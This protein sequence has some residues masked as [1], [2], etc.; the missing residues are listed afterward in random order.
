M[1][2]YHKTNQI[3]FDPISN[4]QMLENNELSTLYEQN[5]IK[6]QYPIIEKNGT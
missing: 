1:K 4:K 6:L 2:Q 5:L 3:P